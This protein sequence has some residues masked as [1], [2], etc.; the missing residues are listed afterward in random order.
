MLMADLSFDN[1]AFFNKI[2][3]KVMA[4]SKKRFED[5]CTPFVLGSADM[6]IPGKLINV[7]SLALS[8]SAKDSAQ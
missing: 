6:A 5:V 1:G 8:S 3:L 4:P 2:L 7:L